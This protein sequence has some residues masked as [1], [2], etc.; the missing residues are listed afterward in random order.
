MKTGHISVSGSTRVCKQD[1]RS[2]CGQQERMGHAW[3]CFWRV[4][5]KSHPLRGSWRVPTG[6]V[7]WQVIIPLLLFLLI[8]LFAIFANEIF[9]TTTYSV[10]NR[11]QANWWLYFRLCSQYMH[12]CFDGFRFHLFEQIISQLLAQGLCFFVVAIIIV[13]M[14]LL[15]MT[16]ERKGEAD[17]TRW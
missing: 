6:R 16:C 17:K 13:E 4:L 1:Q 12:I 7:R 14:L 11:N 9:T 10:F 5:Y 15:V 3:G 2:E 8:P